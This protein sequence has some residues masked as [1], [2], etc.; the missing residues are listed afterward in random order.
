MTAV[1]MAEGESVT[2]DGEL[3]EPVWQRA[4]PATD[5]VQQIPQ[6]GAPATQRTEVRIVY[7]RTTL[8]MG[9]I[10]FDSEPDKMLRY[11]IRRDQ[12]LSSDD[13]F[14]W[15]IDPF[16]TGQ[17]GYHFETNPSG[18]MGEGLLGPAGYNR[19]WDGIWTERVRRTEAGW[20]VEIEI[21]FST[22]NFD[23]AATRVG[24]QFSADRPTQR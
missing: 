16:L 22:L 6:N 9:V 3:D 15:V 24:L 4:V 2:L 8:Y 18:L 19:D 13:R 14:M 5:F 1:R 17:G 10:C 21:P 12:F 7:D 20:T 11:Q 23:P